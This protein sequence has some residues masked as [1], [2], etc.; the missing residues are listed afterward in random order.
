MGDVEAAYARRTRVYFEGV[1]GVFVLGLCVQEL[2]PGLVFFEFVVG[3]E[4]CSIIAH[5]D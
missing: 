4:I 3:R 2:A 5:F 1:V